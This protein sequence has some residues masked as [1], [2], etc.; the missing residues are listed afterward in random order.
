MAW[1]CCAQ[2]EPPNRLTELRPGPSPAATMAV[3][4]KNAILSWFT[5]I[6]VTRTRVPDPGVVFAIAWKR[7]W[8]PFWRGTY[9]TGQVLAA[10]A[11]TGVVHVRIFSMDPRDGWPYLIGLLPISA[12]CL[13]PHIRKKWGIVA[14]GRDYQQ[15]LNQWRLARARDE[16]SCFNVS[17][18]SAVDLVFRSVNP[19]KDFAIPQT[20]IEAAYPVR[21]EGGEFTA[22]RSFPWP[23]PSGNEPS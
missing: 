17:L 6:F 3:T 22:V 12:S 18:P 19:D 15:A 20:P 8:L 13:V 2:V 11:N 9:G 21:G 4:V 16:A 7:Q 23:G 5:N 10:E 14:P 1:L